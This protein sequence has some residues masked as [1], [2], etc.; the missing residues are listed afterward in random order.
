MEA[1][2]EESPDK[3]KNSGSSP[4]K[5]NLEQMLYSGAFA[6]TSPPERMMLSDNIN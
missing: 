2:N 6:Y 4:N 3:S 1:E 5:Q